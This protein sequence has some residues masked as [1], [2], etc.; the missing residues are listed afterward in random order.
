[1][2]AG[3]PSTWNHWRTGEE[4][5]NNRVVRNIIYYANP[6]PYLLERYGWTVKGVTESASSSARSPVFFCGWSSVKAACTESDHNL[7]FPIRGDLVDAL[8][9]YRGAGTAWRGPWADAPVE[10]RFAWWRSQGYE[11]HSIIADP[12]FVDAEHDDFRL[13]PESPA[14]KLGFKPILVERIGLYPSPNRASWPVPE[15]YDIW[16][17]DTVLNLN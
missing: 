9:Y 3:I 1:M 13:K 10:D 7:F 12:L 17:E 15:H 14:F 2:G 6:D 16:R 8:L 4:P 5:C 11:A